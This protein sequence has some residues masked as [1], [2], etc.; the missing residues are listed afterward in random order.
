[1]L[2]S[3]GGLMVR[4]RPAAAVLALLAA[5]ALGA[6]GS[7]SSPSS[8]AAHAAQVAAAKSHVVLL[9]LENEEHNAIVGSPDAPYLNSLVNQY[10]TATTSFAIRH[11]SLPNYLAL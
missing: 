4:L 1:M 10:G 5:I 8:T 2:R 9:V 7:S 11:P 6:C 3:V